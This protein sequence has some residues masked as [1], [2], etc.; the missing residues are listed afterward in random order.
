MGGRRL[1]KIPPAAASAR[2]SAGKRSASPTRRVA[3]PCISSLASG[4]PPQFNDLNDRWQTITSGARAQFADPMIAPA[5]LSLPMPLESNPS[6]FARL[7]WKLIGVVACVAAGLAVLTWNRPAEAPPATKPPLPVSIAWRE[8]KLPGNTQV[9]RITPQAAA[10]L[11][12]RV[13]V[14]ITIQATGVRRTDEWILERSHLKEPKEIGLL[15]GHRFVPGDSL[16]IRHQDYAS[17]TS[18]CQAKP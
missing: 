11:P 5:T 15:E 9:A 4:R 2:T 14:E 16:T 18:T 8:T 7:P 12:L 17:V 6:A 10:L 3:N 13:S 1:A